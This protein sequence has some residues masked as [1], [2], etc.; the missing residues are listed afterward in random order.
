MSWRMGST[1]SR[2]WSN[3]GSKARLRMLTES[4]DGIIKIMRRLRSGGY[5]GHTSGEGGLPDLIRFSSNLARIEDI[6]SH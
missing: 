1:W 3:T 6:F 5:S 4:V 2:T